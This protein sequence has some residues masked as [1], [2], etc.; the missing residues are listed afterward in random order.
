MMINENKL[1]EIFFDVNKPGYGSLCVSFYL[2]QKLFKYGF[3]YD[4]VIVDLNR[5]VKPEEVTYIL[6]K[7]STEQEI[8]TKRSGCIGV[9]YEKEKFV[10]VIV[11]NVNQ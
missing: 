4:S 10:V 3:K 5:N 2:R 8:C 6:N 7:T 1:R 11:E 9:L